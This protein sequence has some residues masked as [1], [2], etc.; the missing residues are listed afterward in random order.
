[1]V[2]R[3]G[4]KDLK[5]VMQLLCPPNFFPLTSKKLKGHIGFGLSVRACVCLCG[6]SRHFLMRAISYKPCMLRF[7]KFHIWIPHGKVAD[8]CFFLVLVTSLSGVMPLRKNQ[9]EI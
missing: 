8:T 2:H 3:P 7:L 9:N 6:H 1:M 5:A 4:S